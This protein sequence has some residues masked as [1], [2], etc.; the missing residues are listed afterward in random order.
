MRRAEHLARIAFALTL[1]L[2]GMVVSLAVP[3]CA[4]V[5]VQVCTPEGDCGV[6][7]I[8]SG[9]ITTAGHNVVPGSVV[10]YPMGEK[11]PAE[12]YARDKARDIAWIHGHGGRGVR[13]CDAVPGDEVS[14]Y[15]Q[16]SR[17]VR[18]TY[19]GRISDSYGWVYEIEGY[20]VEYGHSGS[21][22]VKDSEGCVIGVVTRRR[23]NTAI[24]A[25]LWRGR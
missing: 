19:H 15:V 18:E 1:F 24:A 12:V 9:M 16:R 25:R 7:F 21:P 6:G 5:T 23:E 14:I 20:S 11:I 8:D 22:V 4:P 10:R 13:Y 2:I 17:T 3:G